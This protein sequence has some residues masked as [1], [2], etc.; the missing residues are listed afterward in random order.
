MNNMKIIRYGKSYSDIEKVK[1]NFTSENE[2][3]LMD[4]ERIKNCYMKQPNR[5]NCKICGELLK[6]S[7]T[8]HSHDIRY[9][10]CKK[11]GHINGEKLETEEY[12]SS[13]YESPE[14]DYGKFYRAQDEELYNLRVHNIY[15]PKAEFMLE[16]LRAL[17]IN[18][19]ELTYLDVGAGSGYFVNAMST[20]GLDVKGIEVSAMQVKYGNEMLKS[21]KLFCVPQKEVVSYIEGADCKVISFI[22]VLE[23]VV[24]LEEILCAVSNNKNIQYMYFLVPMFSFSVMLETMFPFVYN[25]V[26]GGAHTHIFTDSSLEYIYKK[27]NMELC[28]EWRFGADI[29]DL[30]RTMKVTM[31]KD[32]NENLISIVDE[33]F[34]SIIDDL[35]LIIDKNHIC[36][37][38]HALVRICH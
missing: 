30:L 9:F 16:A 7:V 13:I 38:I 15:V 22:G 32:G 11:C 31:K 21:R 19:M 12:T 36:S 33:N 4:N 25:R 1:Q 28:G 37:E 18:P 27:Y 24:N 8:F 5:T 20:M 35:Q 34:H 14:S 6:E 3:A 26:L 2:Y 10:I 23:H 17:K 29:A